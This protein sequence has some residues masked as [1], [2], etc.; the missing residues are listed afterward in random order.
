M[1]YWRYHPPSQLCA[2]LR[3]FGGFC[4]LTGF[5]NSYQILQQLPVFLDTALH[6]VSN[7]AAFG[8]SSHGTAK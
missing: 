1:S 5:C 4:V 6:S 2:F 8:P 7:G 3:L